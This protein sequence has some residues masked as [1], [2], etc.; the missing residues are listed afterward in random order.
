MLERAAR[1]QTTAADTAWT[2][3]HTHLPDGW[4]ERV[5]V[6]QYLTGAAVHNGGM[7]SICR[8]FAGTK[9]SQDEAMT[10]MTVTIRHALRWGGHRTPRR[11]SGVSAAGSGRRVYEQA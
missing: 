11:R 3:R 6:S 2:S 10:W 1:G 7:R 9:P 4:D 8:V 5:A